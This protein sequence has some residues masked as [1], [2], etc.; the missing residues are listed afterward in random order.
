MQLWQLCTPELVLQALWQHPRRRRSTLQR[1]ARPVSVPSLSRSLLS[2]LPPS[3]PLV[4]RLKWVIIIARF[5]CRNWKWKCF[6][7]DLCHGKNVSRCQS[8]QLAEERER[9][10]G[11]VYLSASG[12]TRTQGQHIKPSKKTKQRRIN[13]HLGHMRWLLQTLFPSLRIDKNL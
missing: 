13:A 11:Q 6:P 2:P 7:F 1:V 5:N 10:E 4:R 12:S 8:Q 3:P 9:G